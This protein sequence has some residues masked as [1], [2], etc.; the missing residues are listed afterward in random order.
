[1]NNTIRMIAETITLY[2]LENGQSPI[3]GQNPTMYGN[4]I[5]ACSLP[6]PDCTWSY[7]NMGTPVFP[8]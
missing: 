6:S 8:S 2:H 5:R 3:H 7:N 1:M 4:G